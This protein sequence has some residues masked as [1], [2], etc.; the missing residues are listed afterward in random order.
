MIECV[1][2]QVVTSTEQ[3]IIPSQIRSQ[4]CENTL[5]TSRAIYMRSVVWVW[6]LKIVGILSKIDIPVGSK[7]AWVYDKRGLLC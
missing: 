4:A 1:F 7:R 3:D 2:R 5:E 6:F